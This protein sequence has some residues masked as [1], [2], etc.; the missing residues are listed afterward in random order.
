ME[1]ITINLG[2]QIIPLYDKRNIWKGSLDVY[3]RRT[4]DGP[5]DWVLTAY[6]INEQDYDEIGDEYT[7]SAWDIDIVL[8]FNDKTMPNMYARLVR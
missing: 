3:S 4:E 7:I 8:N 1:N 6:E 5:N 2:K